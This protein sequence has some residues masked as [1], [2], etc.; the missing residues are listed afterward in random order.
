MKSNKNTIQTATLTVLATALALAFGPVQAEQS[1]EVFRLVRPHSQVRLGIGGLTEDSARYG[2]YSGLKDSG[3]FAIADVAIVRRDDQTGTW[4]RFNG[5]NLGYESREMRFE[6]ER[7]G[8]WRY[9]L[10][11]SK[12]PRFSQYVVNTGL[13]GIGGA[14]L[15]TSNITPGA[16]RDVRLKTV[17]EAATFSGQKNFGNGFDLQIKFKNDEKNGGRLFGRGTTTGP[18]QQFLVEPIDHTMRLIDVILGYSGKKLQLKG[19]YY[20]SFFQNDNSSLRTSPS[21]P[22][23]R[24]NGTVEDSILA[25]SPIA[26]PPDNHAHQLYL[27]GGYSFT[28][29]TRANFKFSRSVAIQDDTFVV[30]A[31]PAAGRSSLGGRMETTLAQ[32]GFSARPLP[33]L[34]MLANFK[35][36]DRD[37]QT[38]ERRYFTASTTFNGT[39]E[40]RSL[41]S[42]T[43]K[44]EATYSLPAELLLTGGVDYDSRERNGYP[45]RLVT[46]REE[47]EETSYRVE[48][49]R[50]LGETVNGSI[51]YIQ[52]ERDGSSFDRATNIAAGTPVVA[53]VHLADR[54]R[55]KVR[56]SLTWAPIEPLSV[57]LTGDFSQDSYDK[58]T[59][60]LDK[61]KATFWSLDTSYNFTDEWQGLAWASREYSR[62]V[63]STL[64]GTNN[65]TANLQVLT[66]AFG[67]GVR[68]SLGSAWKVGGDIQYSHN[69]NSYGLTGT[70]AALASLPD[71]QYTQA[72]LK[73]FAE[74]EMKQ[75]LALRLDLVHDKWATNDWLWAGGSAGQYRYTDGTTLSQDPTQEASFIG[76][77]VKYTWR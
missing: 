61:G 38:P 20:G 19:G 71:V 49:R 56:L 47:V 2:Q 55:E 62:I 15:T 33:K 74:Y 63:N 28:P 30:P 51:A 8:D 46:F 24:A 41:R 18:S 34:S 66:E 35:Y 3:V 36:E 64:T 45:I 60:G 6:H 67:L 32:V 5:R 65:W 1:D 76:M 40:P 12:T 59:Y 53:S 37:D 17:R 52:S 9:W 7:Q 29:M 31:E 58:A 69:R 4:L 23:R 57:Q 54:D 21:L 25:V 13:Q 77:S 22:A 68:G 48:L 27:T 11:Y 16:G 44:I 26:L 70:T 42:K 10:D 50:M 72:T 73:L 14:A 43:G 39:N 75:D